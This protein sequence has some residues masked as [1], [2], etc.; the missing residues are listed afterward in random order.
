MELA[1][2]YASPSHTFTGSATADDADPITPFTPSATVAGSPIAGIAGSFVMNTVTIPISSF[3]LTVTNNMRPYEEQA[4]S[5]YVND[6][7][8]GWRSVTGT[9]TLKA[10]ADLLR[11]VGERNAIQQSDFLVTLGSGAG[12]N[13]EIDCNQIEFDFSAV[14]FPEDGSEGEVTLPFVALGSSGEDETSI[15]FK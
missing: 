13:V 3:D 8:P 5:E 15:T 6:V 9:V 12:T 7:T 14:S 2:D 1:V 4:F 11:W 10:R